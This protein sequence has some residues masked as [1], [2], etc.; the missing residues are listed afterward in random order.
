MG[1][2]ALGAFGVLAAAA[3]VLMTLTYLARQVQ[4]GAASAADRQRSLARAR[5]HKRLFATA[6]ATCRQC[7]GR[8]QPD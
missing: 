1:W 8:L 3:A 5:R 6:I 4:H 7:G 2:T